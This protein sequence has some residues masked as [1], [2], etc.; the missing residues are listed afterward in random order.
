MKINLR[1]VFFLTIVIGGLVSSCGSDSP[2]TPTSFTIS[3][4]S[5]TTTGNVYFGTTEQ[6][7]AT[8]S[9]GHALTGTWNSDAPSVATVDGNGLVTPV[10]AGRANINFVASTGQQSGKGIRTL[11]NLT[12][13]FTGSY[14]VSSCSQSGQV[15]SLVNLCGSMS[16]GRLMPYTFVVSTSGDVV[17]GHFLLGTVDFG[18]AFSTA[19]SVGGGFSVVGRSIGGGSAITDATW[20]LAVTRPNTLSGNLTAIM[21]STGLT[22]QGNWNGQVSSVTQSAVF[23]GTVSVPQ[24]L[25]ELLLAIIGG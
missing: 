21:S 12:G 11:A 17:S 9:D 6:M 10:S 18:P 1:L 4:T 16:T 7:R 25:E 24:T 15:A 13:T 3:V 22:G 20:L 5:P 2:T 8:A 19:M 23:S 14:T